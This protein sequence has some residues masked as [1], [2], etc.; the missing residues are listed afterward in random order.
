MPQIHYL[1]QESAHES[2]AGA[3]GVDEFLLGEQLYRVGGHHA[4]LDHDGVARA[5]G[6]HHRARLEA[7]RLGKRRDALGREEEDGRL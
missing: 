7:R 5:L 3:V 1:G 6:D 4:L 2:V